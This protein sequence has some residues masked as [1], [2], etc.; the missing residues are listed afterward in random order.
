VSSH[1]VLSTLACLGHLAFAIVAWRHRGR[2]RFAPVLALLVSDVFGWTFSEL[3][4]RV[5]G[6]REWLI[7]DHLFSS[8]TPA[9]ALHV[10]LLFVGKT[11]A[12]SPLA[13]GAYVVSI[14]AAALA[15]NSTLWWKL[16]L[17][18]GLV[19]LG[20]TTGL[21]VVHRAR[22]TDLEER[23]R[24]ELLLL[25]MVVGTLLGL[26]DLLSDK[27]SFPLPELANVGTLF[28]VALFAVATLRL[29]LLGREVTGDLIGFAVLSSAVL[30][31]AGLFAVRGLDPRGGFW[32]VLALAGLL[33]VVLLLRELGR[34]ASVA[35][36]RQ[37]RFALV[38]R[39]SAQLAHDLRNPLGA[40]KG[41]LQFLAEE[42]RAGRSLD[43]HA[44]FVE[45][46]LEQVDRVDRVVDKYQRM[47]KLEPSRTTTS[48]NQ[49]VRE[50]SS[51]QT[52]AL[53]SV[54]KLELELAPELPDCEIDRDL[55]LLALENL[56]R[57]AG[58]ALPR[59]GTITLRT[60][61]TTLGDG[62]NVSVAD[63]GEGM[64]ARELEQATAEFF[65]T[66]AQGSGL[67]LSFVERVARVHGGSLRLFSRPGKG[68]LVELS[69][70]TLAD[71]SA[72][73]L[74]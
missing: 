71:K 36:E 56:L 15:A 24:T 59:G 67:G 68:T 46:M 39:F 2:S 72:R 63:D 17:A 51:L 55:V 62:V 35:R 29:R 45:L 69:F 73:S 4:Y 12:L 10:V 18:H 30:I 70:P 65:T 28:A 47:V 25:G 38:G 27:L 52:L 8:F 14:G 37:R 64:D 48:L 40:L 54:T 58:E 26:T 33:T 50:L 66:K 11:R 61:A 21:L 20:V 13:I 43:G 41:A 60:S 32:L 23:R 34:A 42:Q 3:A 16:L 44:R 49:L 6:A 9:L 1:Q 31:G 53:P 19:T 7:A 22:T 57:N 5:S 74:G